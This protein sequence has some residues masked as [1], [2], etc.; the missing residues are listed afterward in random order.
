MKI[1]KVDGV[2]AKVVVTVGDDDGEHHHPVSWQQT[3]LAF[4]PPADQF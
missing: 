1:R 4:R 3:G 2:K